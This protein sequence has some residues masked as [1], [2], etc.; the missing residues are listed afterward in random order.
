LSRPMRRELPPTRSAAETFA[1]RPSLASAAFR[2][3]TPLP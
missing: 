3:P 1:R 2:D